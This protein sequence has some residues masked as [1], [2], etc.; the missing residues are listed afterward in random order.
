M[1]LDSKFPN[2]SFQVLSQVTGINE[3]KRFERKRDL[4]KNMSMQLSFVEPI[5]HFAFIFTFSFSL[6]PIQ[7]ARIVAL[8]FTG[9]EY[10]A[11]EIKIPILGQMYSNTI[12]F[13]FLILMLF[14]LRLQKMLEN[15]TNTSKILRK[16]LFLLID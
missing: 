9:A 2:F 13:Q 14:F 10:K 3:S 5:I 1:A 12:L 15:K 16:N 8:T 6:P 4:E 11:V 7:F